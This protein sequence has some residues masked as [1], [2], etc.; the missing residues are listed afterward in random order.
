MTVFPCSEANHAILIA[1]LNNGLIQ[2]CPYTVGFIDACLMGGD[3]QLL[4]SYFGDMVSAEVLKA[5]E[6]EERYEDCMLLKDCIEE[7]REAM[8]FDENF[9][10]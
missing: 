4:V 3:Y 2:I 6:V 5:L 7:Y 8:E 1:L 9:V 10:M